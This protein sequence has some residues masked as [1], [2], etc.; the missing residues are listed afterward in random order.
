MSGVRLTRR[1]LKKMIQRNEGRVIFIASEAAIM[2]S[3]EMPHYSATKTM[4]L[5]LSRSLAELTKG[6]NVTV[7]TIMPVSTL[8]AGV[9]TMLTSLYPNE[10]LTIE[11]AEKRF[12]KENRPTPSF[13]DLFARKK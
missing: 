11:E 7:N 10:K 1:Y 8:T 13:K 12:M 2:P 9:K 6:T 4:Q 5:S 3:Q